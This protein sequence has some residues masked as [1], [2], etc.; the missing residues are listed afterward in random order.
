VQL[1]TSRSAASGYHGVQKCGNGYTAVYGR[2]NHYIGHF[3]TAKEAAIAYAKYVRTPPTPAHAVALASARATAR[4]TAPPPAAPPAAP[5]VARSAYFS[6]STDAA[7]ALP[8]IGSSHHGKRP[9]DSEDSEAK[10]P[11]AEEKEK[12]GGGV[13]RD[14]V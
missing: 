4:A 9:A 14:C 8:P 6:A 10:R 2:T 5:P 12:G 11:R 13:G 3:P 1:F 7:P